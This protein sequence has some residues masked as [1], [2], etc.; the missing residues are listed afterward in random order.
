MKVFLLKYIATWL[1]D[2]NKLAITAIIEAIRIA[3]GRFGKGSEK[4]EF[5]RQKAVTYL[6]SQ[7]GWLVDTVI[8]LL[9]AWTRKS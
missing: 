2:N 9:L 7:S 8:H 1:A 3:D 5:V 4:L 6:Q